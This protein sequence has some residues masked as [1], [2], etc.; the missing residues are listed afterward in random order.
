MVAAAQGRETANGRPA[1]QAQL[2][3]RFAAAL[4]ADRLRP[5]PPPPP[6]QQPPQQQQ[7]QLSP[8]QLSRTC[9]E[10]RIDTAIERARSARARRE[11]RQSEL[12]AAAAGGFNAGRQAGEVNATS[13]SAGVL[14]RGGSAG[15]LTRGGSGL[16]VTSATP[17]ASSNGVLT[18]RA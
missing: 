18:E 16:A 17:S 9:T 12:I 2:L 3:S 6:P 8:H 14:T 11:A 7:Q 4:E 10:L 15:V 13:A 1:S 5:P